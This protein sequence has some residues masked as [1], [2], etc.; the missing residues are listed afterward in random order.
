[1]T[2]AEFFALH[3]V[4]SLDEAARALAL[5]A[6]RTGAVV[7][8]K[9]HVRKGRLKIVTRGVYAVVP[10]GVEVRRFQPDT[11]L[12]AVVARPDAVVAY[13][14]ALELLG[15]A[16]SVFSETTVFAA[17]PRNPVAVGTLTVRFLAPPKALSAS[18]LLHLGTR[19]VDRRGRLVRC[20]GPERTLVEGFRRPGLVGGAEELV[21]SAAGFPTLDL[22]LL[23]E[24]LRRYDIATL[25]SAAG[26]FLERFR[27]VFHV[28]ENVLARFKTRR[29]RSPH[30]L[31]RDHRGGVLVH[32]WNLI[33]PDAVAQA[34]GDLA[35]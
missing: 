30:Y 9:H 8:L 33:L 22:A 21:V 14:A 7:R 10:P 28:P 34:A 31:E 17:A 12:V 13:H 29:P 5:P 19:Q 24:I 2:T 35:R 25:W 16:H 26:W 6:G 20:T 1:M 15:A 11:I 18:R 3:P 27:E 23:E 4:F 32:R